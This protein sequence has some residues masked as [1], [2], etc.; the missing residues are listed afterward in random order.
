[1]NLLLMLLLALALQRQPTKIQCYSSTPDEKQN[2]TVVCSDHTVLDI[3]TNEWPAK[4]TGDGPYRA[5]WADGHLQ[6]LPTRAWCEA[7]T[8]RMRDL[9][10]LVP[11][12]R[13]PANITKLDG[14][15]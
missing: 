7:E 1:M 10:A 13:E 3:P 14:C 4:W 12:G 5:E 9:K 11:Q 6:M 8:K 15:E 2:V